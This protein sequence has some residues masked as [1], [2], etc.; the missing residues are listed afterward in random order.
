MILVFVPSKTNTSLFIFN[1]PGIVIHMLVYVD[2]I[3]IASSSACATEVL[4][5]Q[6]QKYFAVED[7]GRLS[8]FLGIEVV[9]ERGGIILTQKKYV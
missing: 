5:Q 8:Y 1:K 6:L 3:I 7:L 4:I 9:F 2:D